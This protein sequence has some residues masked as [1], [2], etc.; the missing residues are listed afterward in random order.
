MFS[1]QRIMER[2]AKKGIAVLAFNNR[3]HDAISRIAKV[4]EKRIAKSRWGGGA[5]E[6]FAECVDDIDGAIGFAR[7]AGAKEIFL[8][9]H[10]TGCQK[11]IYWAYKRKGRGIKGIVL[12]APMSDWAAEI[13]LKGKKRIDKNNAVA[14]ALVRNGRKH[15]LLPQKLWP[16]PIDA[17]RFLS[18]YTPD[19]I[20]EIFSYAQPKKNPRVLRSIQ[21]PLLVI[22]AEKDEF[23]DRS[24]GR[25][26]DWFARRLGKRIQ[27]GVIADVS[28][29]L[30]G[31]ETKVT[32]LILHWMRRL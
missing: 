9:G 22:L 21:K 5:H 14:R 8:V 29:S 4:G 23:A 27:A 10:S 3:G 1:K 31:G 7:R 12:L 15:E 20:E 30:K 28:H 2:L 26:A 11:S 6:I 17:Q 32:S 24:A 19:S 25:I 13:H 18:L 16:G